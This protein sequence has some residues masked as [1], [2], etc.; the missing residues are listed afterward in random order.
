MEFVPIPAGGFLMGSDT[1][2]VILLHISDERPQHTVN[3]SEYY[4]GKHEVTKAQYAAFV[5][6]TGH[7][8]PSDWENGS[9]PPDQEDHPVVNVSWDDAVAFTQWLSDE[10]ETG[11]AFRL[12]TEAE[13][14]KACRGTSGL[15]YP[16]G[17]TFDAGKANTYGSASEQRHR[18]AST[19]RLAI[20]PMVWPTWPATCGNGWRTGTERTTISFAG[21]ESAGSGKW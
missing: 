19:R 8:V 16:W 15:I 14:E 21:R 5:K 13:W 9:V 1:L 4:I 17:D 6:A 12:C 18:S 10:N 7:A 20:A 2:G 11:M 3:L